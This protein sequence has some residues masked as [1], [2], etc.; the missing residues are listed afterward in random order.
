MSVAPYLTPCSYNATLSNLFISDSTC[1]GIDGCLQL[2]MHGAYELRSVQ[3]IGKQDPYCVITCGSTILKT[4]VHDDGGKLAIW[5]EKF[6]IRLLPNDYKQEFIVFE[7]MDK[8][9]KTAD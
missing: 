4:K 5:E 9:D 2:I 8:N 6:S 3:L 7:V 1:H